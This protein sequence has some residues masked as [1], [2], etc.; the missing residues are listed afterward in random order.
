MSVIS[1]SLAVSV[2]DIGGRV[3]APIAATRILVRFIKESLRTF[4][5]SEVM[6]MNSGIYYVDIG[7][8]TK[9][10]IKCHFFK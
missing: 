5:S 2:F 9:S 4:I 8:Y 3:I 10:V 1:T 6:I 7:S